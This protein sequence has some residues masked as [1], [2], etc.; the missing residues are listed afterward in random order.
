[1]IIDTRE[2]LSRKLKQKVKKPNRKRELWREWT[3]W[4]FALTSKHTTINQIACWSSFEQFRK[5]IANHETFDHMKVWNE[6]L[7]TGEDSRYLWRVA[8]EDTLIL[9]PRESAKS[10]FLAQWVAWLIG[11]HTSP[12]VRLAIK[13]LGV[14]YNLETALPRSRQIQAII[15]STKYKEVFPW[16]RPSRQKWGEKEWMIDLEYAG[17]S[18]TEE[19]Y[20]YVCAGLTSGINSRRCHFVFLDDLIKSP[21]AI[22]ALSVRDLMVST[23]RTVIE[24]CRFDG[25]RAVC[26]GTRMTGNDIY[27]TEFTRENGWKV[28][29]QSALLE[30][31]DGTEYS[32]WE[33]K[34]DKSPGTPLK[35]LQAEREKKPLEFAFQRQNKL[36]AVKGQSIDLSHIQRSVLPGMFTSLVLGADLSAGLGE[37]N[38]YTALVLAGKCEN[39]KYWIIDAW[40]DRLMGNIAKLDAMIEMWQMWLHLLP[41]VKRYSVAKGEWEDVPNVGLSLY[42]DS[43]A[44]GLSLKGDFHD[45]IVER[46]KIE[47][48]LVRPIPASGRGD[49]LTRLRRHTGL[50]ENNLVF[51]NKYGRIMSDQRRP[52]GRLIQ[53]ITEFGT[54]DHDDLADALEL[55][56]T[57]LRSLSPLTKADY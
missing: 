9:A 53:Q 14:S 22:R 1:M 50:F 29:E 28:I 45:H 54:T 48:W 25:A 24:F 36:V 51:F 32:Y 39:D 55:A 27:C 30:D 23:W 5:H 52:M 8:G 56:I 15:Q 46:H 16:V 40:E 19:Q 7:N 26:L 11:L 43:S 37:R 35:R 49:K 20:T 42:F 47:D 41:T 21:D 31:E 13:I 10:T 44:Y 18:C 12:W 34:D 33:P 4:D 17:L 2:N 6:V 38:D 57:G 3:T